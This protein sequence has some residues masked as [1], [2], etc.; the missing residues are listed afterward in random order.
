MGQNAA[1]DILV[2]RDSERTRGLAFPIANK[3]DKS[4]EI[5]LLH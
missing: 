2:R 5:L 1:L 3:G 4:N